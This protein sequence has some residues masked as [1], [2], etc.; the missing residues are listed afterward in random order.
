M[1]A[2]LAKQSAFLSGV[3]PTVGGQRVR[4]A[5]RAASNG[6]RVTMA[7]DL[8]LP[9]GTPAP[10][11]DG[12]LPGDFGFDPLGLG[13]NP[14]VLKWH[15]EAERVHARWAMLA[16]AGILVQE[17]VKPD[18]FWYDAPTKIDLPFGILGLLAFEFFAMH[19][20]EVRRW[21]DFRNPGSVD[22]DPIFQ[23]NK[24][25]AHEVGYPGGVFAPFVPGN[26]DELKLKEIKNGRLA[27]LAF[28][29]FV[30][31][32]QV[33]GK[34]PIAALQEHLADPWATTIFSKAVVIP[35]QA[36]QPACQIPSSVNFQGVTLPTPCLFQGLWP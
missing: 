11:L 34:G 14:D 28:V 15:A 12:S 16:V 19:W 20:V 10:H 29:G 3:R 18:V 7:R 22:Q 21:Q 30:M 33:T 1:A 35:G 26:M 6:S 31:A 27:M 9:G 4:V 17:V 36:V 23:N 25:P 13:S 5:A 8:W 32:A 2:L 24:L